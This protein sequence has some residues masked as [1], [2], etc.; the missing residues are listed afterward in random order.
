MHS[1]ND[2]QVGGDH[3]A[4][5]GDIQHWDF[6]ELNGMGYLEGCATKYVTRWRFKNGKQDL[7][8]AV[9]YITKLIALH[10]PKV[11]NVLG[12][13]FS[14]VRRNRTTLVP[15]ISSRAFADA[16]Q[17]T[18]TEFAVCHMLLH[19]TTADDLKM[20]LELVRGMLANDD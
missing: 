10:E 20:A 11:Y 15:V 16:N 5:G 4:K 8:K 7:E 19:W 1:V 9:H 17:L 3:Y 2:Y 6:V 18:D 13:R 14:F 12:V